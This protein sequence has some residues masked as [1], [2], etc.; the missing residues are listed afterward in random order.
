MALAYPVFDR[1]DYNPLSPDLSGPLAMLKRQSMEVEIA[2]MESEI[3]RVLKSPPSGMSLFSLIENF[4]VEIL[5]DCPSNADE[6]IAHIHMTCKD[7]Q[8][9]FHKSQLYGMDVSRRDIHF[10]CTRL[11]FSYCVFDIDRFEEDFRQLFDKDVKSGGSS[12]EELK[13]NVLTMYKKATHEF[14]PAKCRK[15][16]R[17]GRVPKTWRGYSCESVGEIELTE[18]IMRDFLKDYRYRSQQF[19]I[20]VTVTGV[21][22]HTLNAKY[23]SV[24]SKLYKKMGL[25]K[26]K[27]KPV[28]QWL[29]GGGEADEETSELPEPFQGVA[30]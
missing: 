11:I 18:R 1:D 2:A 26:L 28:F 12:V 24:W 14:T 6:R 7:L 30:S 21:A 27:K 19:D 13:A 4:I 8:E 20:P 16:F 23:R 9:S 15:Y 10:Y 3:H 5:K 29:S 17:L 22:I 25:D